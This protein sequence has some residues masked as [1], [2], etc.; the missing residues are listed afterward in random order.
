M[1]VVALLALAL[2]VLV[3]GHAVSLKRRPHRVVRDDEMSVSQ[4]ESLLA[5]GTSINMGG[6]LLVLGTYIA[7]LK[8]G[9][10]AIEIEM[11]VRYQS[12]SHRLT[13]PDR[14]RKL[15]HSL[16]HCL[17]HLLWSQYQRLQPFKVHYFQ[18]NGMQV[19]SMQPMCP[20]HEF[21][22]GMRRSL[23]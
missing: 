15:K 12:E 7:P 5:S 17:L 18:C 3:S 14:Y 11:L 10:P 6:G 4:R 8:V 23:R 20:Q 1:K 19:F 21:L 22:H 16:P 2:I 9:T 13:V